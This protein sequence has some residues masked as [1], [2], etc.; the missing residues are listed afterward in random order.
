ME[1][2]KY[3]NDSLKSYL[4]LQNLKS[5]KTFILESFQQIQD[6]LNEID[7]RIQTIHHHVQQIEST[8][9]N[10]HHQKEYIEQ[11]N[12]YYNEYIN[13][14]YRQYQL[15]L[16]LKKFVLSDEETQTLLNGKIRGDYFSLLKK[17]DDMHATCSEHVRRSSHY[18]KS[19]FE[20]IDNLQNIRT[21]AL[22]RITRWIEDECKL[23]S[24]TGDDQVDSVV[25]VELKQAINILFDK[26]IFLPICLKH[27]IMSRT[28]H[29]RNSFF[30]ALT[31]KSQHSPIEIYAH[32]PLK[33]IGDILAWIHKSAV[34][35]KELISNLLSVYDHDRSAN[36]NEQGDTTQQRE[37]LLF[38]ILNDI[39]SEL[40]GQVQLRVEQIINKGSSS[41]NQSSTPASSTS[42][43]HSSLDETSIEDLR[44]E[45][46]I[47]YF[48]LAHLLELY[49]FTLKRVMGENC[50]MSI[51][52]EELRAKC[53]D[54]FFVNIKK[55]LNRLLTKPPE[56]TLDLAPSEEFKEVLH[57]LV[58]RNVLT[59]L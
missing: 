10:D 19:L 12:G 32:D 53:M 28:E 18:Q 43:N 41:T 31:T 26:T 37:M 55:D 3:D 15:N 20:I 59:L 47:V 36:Q 9:Q 4:L 52:L 38:K 35:E 33:Y 27:V 1:S 6:E 29:V 57:N 30:M 42:E 13:A 16:F 58:R 45:Y 17:V 50:K 23:L 21:R 7:E 51:Y 22:E 24:Q 48:K 40:K 46:T 34:N 25:E 11:M 49:A 2:T 44:E 39:F 54:K 8:I 14:L 5:H 56:I